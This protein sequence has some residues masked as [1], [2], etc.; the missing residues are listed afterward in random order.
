MVSNHAFE[1]S[2]RDALVSDGLFRFMK[3]RQ[4]S[5]KATLPPLV[6]RSGLLE[7]DTMISSPDQSH[8]RPEHMF[9]AQCPE[10]RNPF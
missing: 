6:C 9:I 10:Q 4:A 7:G 5:S 8:G 1:V 3:G 2:G